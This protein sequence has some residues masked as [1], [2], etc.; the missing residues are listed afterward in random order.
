MKKN[1]TITYFIIVLILG[2]AGYIFLSP[3]FEKIPPTIHFSNNCFW[4]MK[5][6]LKIEITDNTGIKYYSVKM[7]NFSISKELKSTPKKIVV[8]FKLPRKY[9]NYTDNKTLTIEVGDKSKW[10][11]FAGNIVRKKYNVIID[12]KRPVVNTLSHSYGIGRGGAA[13]VIF[14]ASDKF[15]RETFVIV[16][17]IHK[18]KAFPYKEKN[19][20][21]SLIT[22]PVKEKNF[23]AKIVA[24]DKAGNSSKLN[25]SF[26]KKKYNYKVSKIT[27]NENFLSSKVEEILSDTDYNAADDFIERFKI[28]NET[29]RAENEGTLETVANN[30]KL[31]KID[32]FNIFPFHP[33][34][35]AAKK[36]SF[37]DHRFYFFN[38]EKISESWHLGLDLASIKN[39]PITASNSGKVVYAKFTG[40]YGNTMIIY[41]GLGLFSA[42]SHCSTF[43]K[44]EGD[45]VS[46]G[47]IIAKTGATGAV[48]GDHLHFAIFIQGLESQPLEW[49]DKHWIKDNIYK[50][51]EVTD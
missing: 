20:F 2:A 7:G 28:M 38:G 3:D 14:R 18:F 24:F 13:L 40:I 19:L 48:F 12:N 6:P 50:V 45:I 41:H 4:S 21:I 25:V 31:E 34:K 36:A 15:L 46:R 42:Y 26:F 10:Q 11:F 44:N 39:A 22:W 9:R 30:F 16:N 8:D 23:N 43:L 17:K 1:L 33:L 35:N 5:S 29:L 37:G 32:S 49:L 51:M 47:D 27:L